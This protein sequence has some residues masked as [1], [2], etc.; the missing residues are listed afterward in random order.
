MH[1]RNYMAFDCTDCGKHTAVVAVFGML[2]CFD[3]MVGLP[4]NGF[5]D[6]AVFYAVCFFVEVSAGYDLVFYGRSFAH[7]RNLRCEG[8]QEDRN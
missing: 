2:S 5:A 4:R 7:L 6:V 8:D 3:R 1:H